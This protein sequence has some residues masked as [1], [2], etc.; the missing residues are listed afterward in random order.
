[1]TELTAVQVLQ[2]LDAPVRPRREFADALRTS[3]LQEL[4]G[5]PSTET[6][7]APARFPLRERLR[8][9]RSPLRS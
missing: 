3:L 1:M 8:Q 7:E 5:A 9:A 4:E 6:V 2:R